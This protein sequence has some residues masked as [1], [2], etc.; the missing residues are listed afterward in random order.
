MLRTLRI[1]RLMLVL[2]RLISCCK[3]PKVRADRGRTAQVSESCRPHYRN[4]D[5]LAGVFLDDEQISVSE[6][7]FASLLHT[8][9]TAAKLMA[10]D[11]HQFTLLRPVLSRL[12]DRSHRG[13]RR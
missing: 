7:L 1:V 4:I 6:W 8:N 5:Q 11:P 9:P 3:W 2:L 13:R 10:P 12:P